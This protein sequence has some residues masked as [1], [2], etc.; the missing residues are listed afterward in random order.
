MRNR[1]PLQGTILLLTFLTSGAWATDSLKLVSAGAYAGMGGVYTSPYGISVNGGAPALM[2]CDDFT[3]DISV[4]QTWTA[5]LNTLTTLTTSDVSALKFATSPYSGTPGI[6]G[7]PSNV[8][9]DYATAAVLSAQLMSLPKIGT[10]AENTELAGEYSFALWA[11]FDTQLLTSTSTGYG[12]LTSAE[13]LAAQGFL[14]DAQA[15]VAAVTV[16]SGSNVSVDLTKIVV[17]GQTLNGLGVYTP[18]PNKSSSQE[19]LL[20]SMPEPGY[21]VLLAI[22][23]AILAG[24]MFILRRRI[25]GIFN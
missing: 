12:S 13:L 24:L 3:T 2:I 11:V 16:V 9:Q 15:K 5:S 14:S 20:V 22:D 23:L 21:P 6:I 7:G 18:D 8:V 10:G 1:K 4:G 25:V 17:N 19:F